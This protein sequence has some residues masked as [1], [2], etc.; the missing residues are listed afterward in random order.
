MKKIISLFV[1]FTLLFTMLASLNV[2]TSYAAST[3]IYEWKYFNA[4]STNSSIHTNSSYGGK[5]FHIQDGATGTGVTYHQSMDNVS[6]EP[7]LN[8]MSSSYLSN[9]RYAVD[10]TKPVLNFSFKMYIPGDSLNSSRYVYLSLGK[11]TGTSPYYNNSTYGRIR[12]TLTS[13]TGSAAGGGTANTNVVNE[14]S[15]SRAVTGDVWH[16]VNVRVFTNTPGQ[17]VMATYM[18]GLLIGM[19]TSNP[20]SGT[21]ISHDDIGINQIQFATSL[22]TYIKDIRL[23]YEDYDPTFAPVTPDDGFDYYSNVTFN[24]HTVNA[25]T[26]A[27]SVPSYGTATTVFQTSNQSASHF[28]TSDGGYTN[29]IY[30]GEDGALKVTLTPDSKGTA[31][32]A[33]IQNFRKD[34]TSYF[35]VNTTKYMQLSYEVK[36][37]E[38][39]KSATKTQKWSFGIDTS[40]TNKSVYNITSKMVDNRIYFVNEEIEGGY[41]GDATTKKSVEFEASSDK[42]YRIISLLKITNSGNDYIIHTDG[43][44]LDIEAD[45]MYKIYECDEVIN[46]LGNVDGFVLSQARTDIK[47][48]KDANQTP[49]VTY[50]DNIISRIWDTDF[51]TYYRNVTD[52]TVG[53]NTFDIELNCYGGTAVAKARNIDTEKLI[54]VAY[55]ADGKMIGLKIS[56][57]KDITDST[58][59][60]AELNLDTTALSET[61]AKLKAFVF[62]AIGTAVPVLEHA[63]LEL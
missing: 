41:D 54:L 59:G 42:W 48:E 15:K 45:T 25:T 47:T 49:V 9:M 17:I 14:Y 11:K 56:T 58:K 46:K 40:T 20:P 7:F 27:L 24:T 50:Y 29:I 52:L 8:V 61:P 3:T 63:V 35:P 44:V 37:P 30:E 51:S 55:N 19:Y 21:E 43:Y 4:E 28:K 53:V 23:D 39:S 60:L 2:T 22:A 31:T 57:E 10:T 6:D 12:Y 1:V 16:D 13:S 18:D 26:N 62:D 38:D 34:I 33:A 5:D 32:H 36:N